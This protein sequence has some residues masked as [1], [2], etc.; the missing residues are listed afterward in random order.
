MRDG[1]YR[2]GSQKGL[3]PGPAA[4]LSADNGFCSESNLAGLVG[5][6]VRGYVVAG[7]ASK[8]GGGNKGSSLVRV[9]RA[10]LRQSGHQSR[11][12]MRKYVV[13]PV[14]GHIKQARNFR[15]FLLRCIEKVRGE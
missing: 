11:Y 8:P 12:W 15:Q 13:K 3:R 6:T 4:G 9:M 5:R 7:R 14:F 1:C 10:K 2:W